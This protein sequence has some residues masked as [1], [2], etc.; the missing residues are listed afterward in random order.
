MFSFINNFSGSKFE[1]VDRAH[2]VEFCFVLNA[3]LFIWLK[4]V[5]V[6]A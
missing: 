3:Y 4:R 5:L 1:Y 6:A 2:I